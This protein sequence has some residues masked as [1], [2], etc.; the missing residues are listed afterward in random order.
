MTKEQRRRIMDLWFAGHRTTAIVERIG[1]PEVTYSTVNILVKVQRAKGDVR[2]VYHSRRGVICGS[3]IEDRRAS[4]LNGF[5]V[6]PI[7]GAHRAKYCKRGHP[8][9][10]KTVQKTNAEC[11]LCRAVRYQL[12]KQE[13]PQL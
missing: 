2:A 5:A 11:K 6:V 4:E 12:R 9:N 13:A 8:R 7:K 3:N 1:E 10:A